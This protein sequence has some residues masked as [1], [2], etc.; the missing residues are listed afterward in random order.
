[1]YYVC[2]RCICTGAFSVT[3]ILKYAPAL[4]SGGTLFYET[5]GQHDPITGAL[6]RDIRAIQV[7][8]IYIFIILIRYNMGVSVI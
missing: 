6:E 8:G 7:D 4:G 3:Q 2:V 5:T 1:M